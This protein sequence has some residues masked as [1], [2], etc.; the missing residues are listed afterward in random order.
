M[1]EVTP[2]TVKQLYIKRRRQLHSKYRAAPR[3]ETCWAKV[4]EVINAM[5]CDPA[6]YIEAQFAKTYPFPHPNTLYNNRAREFY[7]L[8]REQN[9]SGLG[10]MNEDI[11]KRFQVMCELLARKVAMGF[12]VEELLTNDV[13]GFIPIFRV[14]MS[15]Y[16]FGTSNLCSGYVEDAKTEYDSHPAYKEVYGQYLPGYR[17][18]ACP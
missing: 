3:W 6:D 1:D 7:N 14:A 17:K 2:K 13:F 10:G 18:A 16:Y 15:Y 8:Y 12:A 4:A 9:A 11:H 5:Q